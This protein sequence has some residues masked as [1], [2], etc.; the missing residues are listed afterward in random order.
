MRNKRLIFVWCALSCL[1]G[2]PS[3]FTGVLP[4]GQNEFE[5]V[6]DRLEHLGV[7]T[8]D[9]YDYQLG[10][11]PFDNDNFDFGPF[12]NLKHIEQDKLRFFADIGEDFRVKRDLRARGYETFRAGIA[13][14]PFEK[15]FVYGNFVLDEELAEDETY[16]GKKWRGFAGDVERAF[17]HF[18]S[19]D[20]NLTAGRYASFWGPRNSLV[21]AGE[22]ELDGFGYTYRWGRLAITYRQAR[23]DGLSP[24]TDNV[25]AYENRYFA[26]HR[27]DFH[28]GPKLRVG[29][30][31][32]VVFGGPGRQIDLYYLNPL[33]FFHGSQLNE[34]TNDNT[35]VGFDFDYKPRAGVKIYG[36]ALFDDVQFDD[37][38]QSDQEPDEYG[39]LAGAYLVDF[40][41][42][43]DIR[44]EYGRVVN[45][46]FNQ[47]FERNRY[48]FNGDLLGRALGN[49]YDLSR[50]EISR[51]FSPDMRASCEIRY[52]RQGEGRVTDEWSEPWMEIEGDY[53][54]PFPTG[55]VE[56]T[57]RLAFGIKTFVKDM[58][59]VDIYAG[60][61]RVENFDHISGDDRTRPFFNLII[62]AFV[63]S[64]VNL[65]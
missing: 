12:E 46:T 42:P 30:F 45:R 23:L 9:N 1:S 44:L 50:L 2:A 63:S 61:D 48:V 11:Y 41:V 27:F 17:I 43:V 5:F 18:H 31:E 4:L 29:L 26:G 7:T 35:L 65:K 60:L 21:L 3:V 36:Q 19:G 39:F 57:L 14:Q 47:I 33:I 8:L 59:F 51:W 16:T 64:T 53:S 6:Y 24:E 13:G 37:K 32:T 56:E 55:T 58:F 54:E 40:L 15:L 10:P 52:F 28:F 62:S 34:G 38:A 20:F 22:V 25:S 49:D